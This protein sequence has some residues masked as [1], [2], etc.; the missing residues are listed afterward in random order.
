[1]LQAKEFWRMA[2]PFASITQR[3]ELI[4]MWWARQDLNLGMPDEAVLYVFDVTNRASMLT[5]CDELNRA[6][7]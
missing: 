2:N 6:G 3:H 4:W 5:F 7:R 1:M